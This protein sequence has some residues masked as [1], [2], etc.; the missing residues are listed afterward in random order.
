MRSPWSCSEEPE[1]NRDFKG[2]YM[3]ED[4][5]AEHAVS[6]EQLRKVGLMGRCFKKIKKWFHGI[7]KKDGQYS[8]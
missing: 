4:A 1:T 3:V 2:R 7:G 8:W 5:S 6:S